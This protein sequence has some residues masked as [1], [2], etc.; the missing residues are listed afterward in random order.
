MNWQFRQGVGYSDKRQ[1]SLGEKGRDEVEK[2]SIDNSGE[3]C[4]KGGWARKWMCGSGGVK[5]GFSF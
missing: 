1:V 2:F 4:F 5:E 3:L